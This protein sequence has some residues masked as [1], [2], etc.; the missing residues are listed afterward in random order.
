MPGKFV[1][2]CAI[3]SSCTLTKRQICWWRSKASQAP[4]YPFNHCRVELVDKAMVSLK[5]GQR[6][7]QRLI[8]HKFNYNHSW[9]LRYLA[10]S[11]LS[12]SGC[13][14]CNWNWIEADNQGHENHNSYEN[15]INLPELITFWIPERCVFALRAEKFDVCL[16]LSPRNDSCKRWVCP[17]DRAEGRSSPASNVTLPPS[18]PSQT[19]LC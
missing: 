17:I 3:F 19:P 10:L 15:F 12:R 7:R 1:T 18:R 9:M 13:L 4:Q 16:F 2:P 11:Q 6:M 8:Q 5:L 14:W